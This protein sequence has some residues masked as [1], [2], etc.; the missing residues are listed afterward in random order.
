VAERFSLIEEI[1]RLVIAKAVALAA[2]RRALGDPAGWS[3]NLSAKSLAQP[4]LVDFIAEHID[5]NALDPRALT[6]EIT[7]TVAVTNVGLARTLAEGLHDLGCRLALDDFGAGF[8]SFYYLKH[9]PFDVLKIDGE[10]V[11]GCVESATDQLII[12]AVVRVA[13]GLGKTTVAEFTGDRATADFL[14]R[15]GVDRAQGFY[16]GR[17]EPVDA[18]AGPPRELSV[19]KSGVSRPTTGS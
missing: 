6:F 2:H 18:M 15:A 13:R 14:R 4:S 17:P 16:L 1:D 5:R 3:I 7:E 12:D 10:F 19:L 11:R 8:G 9:L